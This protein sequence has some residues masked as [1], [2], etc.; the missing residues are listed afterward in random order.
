MEKVKWSMV[1]GDTLAFNVE[2]A[3][4]ESLASDLDSITFSC[5]EDTDS[6]SYIFKKTLGD[7]V[8]RTETGKYRVRVAPEDT[9][10]VEPGKYAIDLQIGVNND[11]ATPILGT[12]T[13]LP[14][15]T[16]VED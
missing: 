6:N 11:I 2:I 14:D 13:I 3:D 4:A 7:G 5:K 15:V 9:N 8:T 10:N 12:L 1:R 16:R